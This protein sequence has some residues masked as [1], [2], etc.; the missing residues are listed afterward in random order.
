MF[1]TDLLKHVFRGAREKRLEVLSLSSSLA[2]TPFG[3]LQ[4]FILSLSSFS[5]LVISVSQDELP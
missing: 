5:F 2:N 1:G 3:A 4:F